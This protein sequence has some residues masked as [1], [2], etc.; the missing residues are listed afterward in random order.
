MK[1]EKL[2]EVLMG[3]RE[4]MSEK[5]VGESIQVGER[6]LI[7]VVK[8]SCFYGGGKAEGKERGPRFGGFCVTP[9]AFVVVDPQGERVLSL[10]DEEFSLSELIVDAPGLAEKIKEAREER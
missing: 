9:L 3:V 2:K 6:T 7:P 4:K 10:P 5:V 8:V 1:P